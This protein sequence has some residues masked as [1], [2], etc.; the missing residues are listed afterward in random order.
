MKKIPLSTVDIIIEY[1]EGIVLIKRKNPPFGWA[2]PGG[3]VDYDESL[4]E[5]AAREAKEE[6]N[7][8]ITKLRQFHAYSAP[9]RDPRGHT[10]SCVFIAEGKGKLKAKTDAKD[11][12]IFHKQNLP[13]NFAFDHKKIISDYFC[14]KNGKEPKW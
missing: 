12:A 13:L 1:Q 6:T 3:F 2:I 5:A 8:D 7:L 11:A 10:I 9:G 14:F 4:E